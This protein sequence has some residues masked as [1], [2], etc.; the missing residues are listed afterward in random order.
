VR[1]KT[2]DE[3][4]DRIK[5]IFQ[6]NQRAIKQVDEWDGSASNWPD[7]AAYCQDCLINVNAEAGNTEQAD[8][9]QSHCMLPIRE[10][11]DDAGTYVDQAVY[12]AAGGRGITAVENP[13]IPDDEWGDAVQSAAAEIISAYE[14]MDEVAPDSVYEAAGMEPPEGEERALSSYRVW[15]MLYEA[16][17]EARDGAYFMDYYHEDG[18][19]YAL[20][21]WDGKLY[22]IPFTIDE[23]EVMLNPEWVE[24]MIVHE[25]VSARTTTT[26]RRTAEGRWR[27]FSVSCTAVLNRV[28]EIDG[29][30]LFDSFTENV[31]EH[32]YPY[33]T[34][35]HQGEQFRTGQCDFLAR[36]GYTLITSG[37]YDDTEIAQREITARQKDPDYWGES[38]G[39]YPTAEPEILRL[40]IEEDIEIPVFV[41]GY[42]EEI[43]TAPEDQVAALFTRTTQIEQGED[44]ML[45]GRAREAF[46]K[47]FGGDKDAAEAW[48]QEN[49]DRVNQRIQDEGMI[50]RTG[51]G[52]EDPEPGDTAGSDNP[53]HQDLETRTEPTDEDPAPEQVLLARLAEIVPEHSQALTDLGEAFNEATE[54]IETLTARVEALEGE[55][56]ARQREWESDLPD[57]FKAL[58][59]HRPSQAR[60]KDD[61]DDDDEPDTSKKV[62][63]LLAEKGL[64]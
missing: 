35:Y 6:P 62:E 2:I 31:E 64:K 56:E 24:V 45:E 8:W 37:L 5:R 21:V 61:D 27:W 59:L 57:A 14:Q 51:D 40:G 10:P 13:G 63:D 17:Y 48:M 7:T 20:A 29:S 11:G 28:G 4:W 23:T 39:Y 41:Q 25:P 34:F 54:V 50:A 19:L 3:A 42:I 58:D 26:I 16:V 60:A 36:D 9:V 1:P 53:N 38:I 30:D 33:R 46:L 47:L 44:I 55:A 49:T 18:S 22:R 52:D 43:S 32:G 12:A 15:D